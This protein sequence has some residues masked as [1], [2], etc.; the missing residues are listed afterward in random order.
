[1]HQ[2][3]KKSRL[4]DSK[5]STYLRILLAQKSNLILFALHVIPID[6]PVVAVERQTLLLH[7]VVGFSRS[8]IK[9]VVQITAVRQPIPIRRSNFG[10]TNEEKLHLNVCGVVSHDFVLEVDVFTVSR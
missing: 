8:P 4:V 6:Q 3:S 7:R 9:F 10:A 5:S 2:A 1:M